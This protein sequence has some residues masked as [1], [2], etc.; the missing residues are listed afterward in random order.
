MKALTKTQRRKKVLGV[1]STLYSV[2]IYTVLYIPVVVMM[3]FSFN[4]QRYNYYW[5]GFTT[6]WYGKLFSNDALIGSLWYSLVIAVLATVISV[7]IGTLGAL[8]LKRFE[9]RGKKLINNML[10]VPIIVPEIVLAVAL[11][12]IFMNLGLALGMGSILI[13]HCTF[14]IPY[15]VVTIKGRI[16]GDGDSL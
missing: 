14:C 10:Y 1:L 15:A 4:D 8:G 11:L 2:L 13:G 3:I 6:Q 16:S 12:I 5:N 7:V 9:F